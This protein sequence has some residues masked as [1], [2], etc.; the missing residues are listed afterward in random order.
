MSQTASPYDVVV[1]GGGPGGSTAATMLARQGLRALLLERDHFPRE[2]VGESLLPASIPV[3]EELGALPAIQQAGFLQKWG[4]TMVWGKDPEPWSWYFKETNPKYPHSYQVSRPEFDHILLDNSRQAGVEVRE[5]YRATRVTFE[6]GRAVG[7]RC[8]SSTKEP[9]EIAAG[10]VVDA[11][12]QG[13]LLA[14]QLG[15]RQWDPFFRNLAVYGYFQGAQRLPEPDET[16][17]FIESYPQG[18]LWTIP[19][20]TGLASVG[21]VVDSETGQEGIRRLGP[22]GFLMD[23]L[24]QGPATAEMLR[25][26]E[27]SSGPDVVRDWSY[28]CKKTAGPGYV[29]VGDAACF[30]DPLFSSGVHLALMSG[31]L[32]AALVTSSLSDPDIE[33][34][35]GQVYQELYI[36]EYNQFRELA[37]LFYSSNLSSDSYFWE[38]RRLTG[39]DAAFTPRQ[40][41]I[42]TVAGQPPRGY[43][44]AVLE[45]GDAPSE[46]ISS[47][48]QVETDRARRQADLSAFLDPSGAM[49]HMFYSA[50]PSL[51]P[52]VTVVR[53]PVLG[54][55]R[56]DW[57][58]VIVT[59]SQPEGTPCSAL[60]AEVASAID[61]RTPVRGLMAKLQEDRDPSSAP[62]I[63]Q[64]V[65]SAV[66][67]LYVDETISELISQ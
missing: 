1:I 36:Q 62:I 66:Q 30:V 32:A 60:V 24:S 25:K 11:S 37:R 27:L 41:F 14:R 33:E 40:A 38:A 6:G 29:L 10:F 9:L 8:E 56:F 45:H 28:V 39:K 63:E 44:R 64:T 58:N 61:G 47:V 46:F 35:A 48:G 65:V 16:N 31:V 53:K 18:W 4:A 52:G 5:G 50:V 42:R 19:L 43:E 7:V 21:A 55:G 57:G 59:P 20:H 12:G 34:A 67:I 49:H 2:H 3:L 23:Q 26:A 22:R 13:G 54:E 51:A 15:L 17:I